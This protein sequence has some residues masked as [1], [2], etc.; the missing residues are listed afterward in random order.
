[1]RPGSRQS[2]STQPRHPA[3]RC[4]SSAARARVTA[5][6]EHKLA[7]QLPGATRVTVQSASV[8]H[9]ASSGPLAC[10]CVE[11]WPASGLARA[12]SPPLPRE[13][14]Q[15]S[16]AFSAASAAVIG[17]GAAATGPDG[18]D[19]AGVGA[20]GG[21]AFPVAP[22]WLLAH[23]QARENATAAAARVGLM[24]RGCA[25]EA[26]RS[27]VAVHSLR[28]QRQDVVETPVIHSLV[29]I[30]NVGEPRAQGRARERRGSDTVNV[31]PSSAE[32]RTEMSPPCANTICCT[33]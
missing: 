28:F 30:G 32:E 20:A 21:A 22:L 2:G 6:G 14:L 15:S 25:R 12:A 17:R 13:R 1:M 27:R 7:Q 19:A 24:T 10:G 23:A 26:S 18:A 4:S 5:R 29:A 31:V 16:C 9:G 11:R 8:A 3:L 33:M